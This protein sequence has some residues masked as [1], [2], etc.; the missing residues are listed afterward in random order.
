MLPVRYVETIL[1]PK[2]AQQI[3]EDEMKKLSIQERIDEPSAEVLNTDKMGRYSFGTQS[4]SFIL[5][6]TTVN[7]YPHAE[8]LLSFAAEEGL[9]EM[10][11]R[12]TQGALLANYAVKR[13][14]IQL[15]PTLSDIEKLKSMREHYVKFTNE[16]IKVF[17]QEINSKANISLPLLAICKHIE[18]ETPDVSQI[19][20][21]HV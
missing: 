8:N 20:R 15:N 9:Q 13:N 19:G 7:A 11:L 2:Q 5:E 12:A 10:L 6:N 3:V 1:K 16:N 17:L 4:S 14:I 18:T 21:A